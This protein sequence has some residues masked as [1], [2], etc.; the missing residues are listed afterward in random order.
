MLKSLVFA[1]AFLVLSGHGWAQESVSITTVNQTGGVTAAM[2]NNWAVLTDKDL[3][4]PLLSIAEPQARLS[5]S[6]NG[7]KVLSIP[8]TV[9]PGKEMQALRTLSL[10]MMLL[11]RN[12]PG[13]FTWHE[14]QCELFDISHQDMVRDLKRDIA[15]HSGHCKH[16][17]PAECLPDAPPGARCCIKCHAM[18]EGKRS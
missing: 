2:V 13:P 16:P 18:C 14:I 6:I 9:Q 12:N 15:T 4:V 11:E 17:D 10:M 5:I 7:K 8:K 3:D 1:A